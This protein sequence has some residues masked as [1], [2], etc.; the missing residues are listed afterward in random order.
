MNASSNDVEET[1]LGSVDPGIPKGVIEAGKKDN[2]EVLTKYNNLYMENKDLAGWIKIEGTIIDYPVMLTPGKEEYYLNRNFKKKDDLNGL[3]FLN[4]ETDLAKHNT[5]M[6]IYGHHMKTGEM[7]GS[8]QDYKNKKYWEEHKIIEFDTIYEEGQ[9]EVMAVFP[10]KV[11]GQEEN[12]FKY[13]QFVNAKTEEEFQY[14]LSNVKSLS[15]YD[16]GVEAKYGDTFITLSTCD[17]EE[18]DGRFVVVARKIEKA[19]SKK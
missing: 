12:V 11:Y 1:V 3:P 19:N 14:F 8:L 13:Y 2:L 9:Y 5:N 16:T 6:I 18:E 4:K 17:Y 7:F 10:S 15:L